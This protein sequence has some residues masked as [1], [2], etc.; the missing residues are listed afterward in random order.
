[1]KKS[2]LQSGKYINKTALNE[3]KQIMH[4]IRTGMSAITEKHTSQMKV[5]PKWNKIKQ[6]PYFFNHK[7]TQLISQ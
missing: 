4:K 7:K 5:C 6:R 2:V 1:M 3:K